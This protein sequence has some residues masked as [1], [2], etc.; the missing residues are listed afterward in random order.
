MAH[1]NGGDHLEETLEV[2]FSL[3]DVGTR[4]PRAPQLHCMLEAQVPWHL[5]AAGSSL[6]HQHPHRG[7]GEQVH[8]QLLL[9]HRRR[10]AAQHVHAEDRRFAPQIELDD[11]ATADQL[12]ERAFLNVAGIEQRRHQDTSADLC[13]AH[14]QVLGCSRVLLGRRPLGRHGL[15]H[16]TT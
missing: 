11:P 16:C 4:V 5:T 3:A 1:S 13:F 9:D 15:I 8:P 14:G 12:A 2:G 6:G 10:A 7:V